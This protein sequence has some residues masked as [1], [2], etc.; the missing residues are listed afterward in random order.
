VAQRLMKR[1]R[2]NPRNR[3]SCEKRRLHKPRRGKKPVNSRW[4][5]TT[6]SQCLPPD[7]VRCT[8]TPSALALAL[9]CRAHLHA[10]AEQRRKQEKASPEGARSSRAAMAAESCARSAVRL[11]LC[12]AP[13][14][15]GGASPGACATS[16]SEEGSEGCL[17]SG[18]QLRPGDARPSEQEDEVRCSGVRAPPPGVTAPLGDGAGASPSRVMP[19][20]WPPAWGERGRHGG[21]EMQCGRGRPRPPLPANSARL[22]SVELLGLAGR[23]AIYSPPCPEGDRG[24]R[25][26]GRTRGEAVAV[27]Q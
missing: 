2:V 6:S 20:R 24:E 5:E 27:G 14:A 19:T 15:D 22:T 13:A 11:E 23:A 1:E 17:R 18:E 10:A 3:F 25:A 7:P 8:R 26:S 16:R 4:E 9:G 21:R 12:V